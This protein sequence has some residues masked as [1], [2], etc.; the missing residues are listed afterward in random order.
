MALSLDDTVPEEA[1]EKIRNTD[2]IMD[3][4]SVES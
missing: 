1:L 4:R 2:G 3:V